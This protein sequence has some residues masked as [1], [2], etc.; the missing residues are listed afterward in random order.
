MCNERRLAPATITV[1]L[2]VVSLLVT[3][4]LVPAQNPNMGIRGREAPEWQIRSWI[5]KDGNP[6]EVRLADYKGKVVYL[7]CFQSW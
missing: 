5:D 2:A 6:T 3:R 4:E 7:F 1:M